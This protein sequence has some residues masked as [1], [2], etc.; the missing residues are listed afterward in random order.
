MPFLVVAQEASC[1]YKSRDSES[2]LPPPGLN[3]FTAVDNVRRA[4]EV[5]GPIKSFKA[6]LDIFSLTAKAVPQFQLQ[7]SGES[8]G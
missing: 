8:D 1:M 4:A 2:C 3:G 6:Y 5:Y 7:T